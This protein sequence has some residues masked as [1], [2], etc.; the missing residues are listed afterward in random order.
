[1]PLDDCVIPALLTTLQGITGSN[2][3]QVRAVRFGEQLQVGQAPEL[4]VVNLAGS[5][6]EK[7]GS[8]LEQSDWRIELRLIYPFAL[9]QTQP[10]V[11]LGKLIEPMRDLFRQHL[12]MGRPDLIA[13]AR[14][15]SATWLWSVINETVYRTVSLQL[16]VREKT[17]ARF[18]P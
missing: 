14:I 15:L 11:V 1:M 7:E 2:D 13:R 9:D 12:K 5:F 17:S 4:W 3:G 16:A 10:E 8:N 18:N 6:P